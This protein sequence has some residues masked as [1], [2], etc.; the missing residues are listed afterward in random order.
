MKS[1]K[2]IATGVAAIG[3]IGAAAI[4]VTS[5]AAVPA[6]SAA[7]VQLAAVGAPFPQDP[8][9]PAP[10]PAPAAG[11]PTPAQLNGLLNTLA[12]PSVSFTST[13]R[14]TGLAARP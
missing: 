3:A 5:I 6:G 13:A 7:A 4:G 8:P 9:P 14:S 10:V 1:V 12:D 11:V 2:A